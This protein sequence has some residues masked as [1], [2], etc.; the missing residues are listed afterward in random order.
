MMT[1]TVVA[2]DPDIKRW[3]DD[4]ALKEGVPM[5]ELVRQGVELLRKQKEKEL[6]TILQS[7]KGIWTEGDGLEYERKVRAEWPE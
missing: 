3:L 2:M 5:T 7:C 1:R 6:D 4:Q